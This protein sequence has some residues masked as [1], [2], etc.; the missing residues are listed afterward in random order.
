M[1]QTARRI[2]PGCCL[3]L[4]ASLT[5]LGL[6]QDDETELEEPTTVFD[7]S[8]IS[9]A[10]PWFGLEVTAGLE[11]NEGIHQA[12]RESDFGAV[13]G[14]N[15]GFPLLQAHGIGGQIGTN[16]GIYDWKGRFIDWDDNSPD[17][18]Q[19]Q[20]FFTTGIFKETV[21]DSRL[22]FG[23]VYDWLL[24]SNFGTHGL[25]PAVGQWR[26]RIEYALSYSNE[27]GLDVVRRD[28]GDSFDVSSFGGESPI[29]MEQ[30]R[31]ISYAKLYWHHA[32]T[33]G[34]HTRL[35]LGLPEHDRLPGYDGDATGSVIDLMVGASIQ[36]PLTNSLDLMAAF[37]W[38]NSSAGNDGTFVQGNMEDFSNIAISL[39][40]YPGR[41]TRTNGVTRNCW[42][43]YMPVA[44]NRNLLVDRGFLGFAP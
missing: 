22:S 29:F 38:C 43:P 32:M 17:Q 21:G 20:F 33:N 39:V 12:T 36:T 4:F 37:Q 35:W 28:L 40:Y 41:N 7:Y 30:Y 24:T 19:H 1:S 27:I 2:L 34:T 25:N 13:F 44:N 26:G 16:W 18:A 10:C 6:C 8:G 42:M 5:Q 15:L 11:N 23:L 3:A 9:D 31:A 14:A